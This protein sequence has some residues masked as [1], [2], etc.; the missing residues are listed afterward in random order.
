MPGRLN[1]ADLQGKSPD[2][3][4]ELE[5]DTVLEVHGDLRL[6]NQSYAPIPGGPDNEKPNNPEYGSLWMNTWTGQLEYWKGPGKGGWDYINPGSAGANTESGQEEAPQPVITNLSEW[7]SMAQADIPH[8]VQTSA[9]GQEMITPQ[10]QT[11]QQ[12]SKIV[13]PLGS[14]GSINGT[15]F[16]GNSANQTWNRTLSTSFVETFQ[17]FGYIFSG[18]RLAITGVTGQSESCCDPYRYESMF[19]STYT[20]QWAE[21]RGSAQ[22]NA[23]HNPY[24]IQMNSFS[25]SASASSNLILRYSTDGSVNGGQGF[26]THTPSGYLYA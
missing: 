4:I 26:Y 10:Q 14:L 11:T 15:N 19:G 1:V 7:N 18:Q 20:G 13:L 5:H 8:L 24:E 25:S 23:S 2:F 16:P 9:G 3:K 12:G 22:S 21:I 6:N 17:K